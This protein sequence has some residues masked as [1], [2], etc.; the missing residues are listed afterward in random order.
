MNAPASGA[1]SGAIE[2]G[3]AAFARQEWGAAYHELVAADGVSP[4]EPADLERLATTAYLFGR[5]VDSADVWARAHHAFL[6]R[7]ERE[8]AVRCA[9]WLALGLLLKG[10]EARGGGWLARA[11]RLLD[12]GPHDC[13]EQGYLLVPIGL[14]RL[15]GGDGAG[16][17][18]TFEQAGGIGDRFRDADLTTFALLGR[19]Q[20]LIRQGDAAAGV[21]MLDEAMVAVTGGEVSP[22]VA[23]LVYCA[24]I[25]ECQRS[26]DLRRAQQWTAAL[27]HWCASQPELVPY[28]GQCLVYRVEIMQ[29]RG[30]WPDAM[31]EVR[32]ACERLSDPPGQ[33]AVG[34]AFYQ[35]AELHRLRGE[36][37]QAEDAYRRANQS[38]RESQPGLGLLRLAQGRIAVAEAAIHRVMDEAGGRLTRARL[39]PSYVEIT[40]A[41]DD[42]SAARDAADEL[43]GIAA[44]VD[45]PLLHAV[46]DHAHAAV[47]LV[48]GEGVG[49]LAVARRAWTTWHELDVP[50]EAARARVHVARACRMLGDDDGA[51]MELDAARWAL[52][53][54]GAVHDVAQVEAL[55]RRASAKAAGG[56]TT[57]EVQVLRLVAAG[58]TNRAVAADLFLSEKTVARHVSNILGKLGLS[59]RSAATAYAYEHD[60]V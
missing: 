9:F 44:D 57:R 58:K 34:M 24:V 19:G 10:E 45:T 52:Q 22:T 28:R 60:L 35:L 38:G 13:V 2:R 41:A 12:D 16:A 25:E 32:R 11:R 4:L 42:V 8:R 49:A 26:F 54:L 50:Y 17:Y 20:A 40:L 1:A 31:E 33:P 6:E 56:L 36:F 5:D 55:L 53:Q 23:G 46:A 47:L 59:S 39:L 30:T 51:R 15:A 48:E 3:R 7:G 27:T 18:A 43:S 37:E 14:G 21:T 29:L